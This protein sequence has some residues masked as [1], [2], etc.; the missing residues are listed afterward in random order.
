LE[1]A[2]GEDELKVLQGVQLCDRRDKKREKL[3]Q[4][5]ASKFAYPSFSY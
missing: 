4:L 3:T 5:E 1:T 2:G